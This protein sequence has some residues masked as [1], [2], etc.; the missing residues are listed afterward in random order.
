MRACLSVVAIIYRLIFLCVFYLCHWIRCLTIPTS[1]CLRE[2]K[3][4]IHILFGRIHRALFAVYHEVGVTNMNRGLRIWQRWWHLL[5]DSAVW[6][7]RWSSSGTFE[8][9]SNASVGALALLWFREGAVMWNS[10]HCNRLV[11][12]PNSSAWDSD[13]MTRP[14]Q[15][16]A[17]TL[18]TSISLRGFYL[19]TLRPLLLKPSCGRWGCIEMAGPSSRLNLPRSFYVASG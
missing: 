15:L 13:Q 16:I 8:L 11:S 18:T 2:M 6:F 19:V 12:N 17:S 9:Y 5:T 14:S 3:V 4:Q 1:V 7:T 10:S